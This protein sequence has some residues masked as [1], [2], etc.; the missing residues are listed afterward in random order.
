MQLCARYVL[1]S[2]LI[3]T[4]ELCLY[5]TRFYHES[6]IHL[7]AILSTFQVVCFALLNLNY[8]RVYCRMKMCDP[9]SGNIG[10]CMNF[11]L[12]IKTCPGGNG[13]RHSNIQSQL[14][15]ELHRRTIHTVYAEIS[16]Q[17]HSLESIPQ[18]MKSF[19]NLVPLLHL[20]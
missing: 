19:G 5:D 11:C 16:W 1:F 17:V 14:S 10:V 9:R 8:T 13:L 7:S 18:F 2:S 3:S 15:D 20:S 6:R 12:P 4:T